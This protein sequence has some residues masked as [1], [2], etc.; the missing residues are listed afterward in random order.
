MA[1][2]KIRIMGVDHV[3]VDDRK[4]NPESN[5][6]GRYL[7]SLCKITIDPTL[8]A[9]EQGTTLIHEILEA[10]NYKL[11]M[12]DKEY[13]HDRLHALAEAFYSVLRDN[14]VLIRAVLSGKSLV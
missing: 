7:A 12:K 10:L 8:A 3:L 2:T 1:N 6:A 13:T 14:P 9:Q 11:Q 5:S 4:H